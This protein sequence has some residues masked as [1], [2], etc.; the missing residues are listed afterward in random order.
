MALNVKDKSGRHIG[1]VCKTY[2]DHEDILMIAL[3]EKVFDGTFCDV[4]EIEDYLSICYAC[5][6]IF[7]KFHKEKFDS[8]IKSLLIGEY[9][10]L[11]YM[12]R[13]TFLRFLLLKNPKKLKELIHFDE[14]EDG[15]YGYLLLD[16][17]NIVIQGE[18]IILDE[19]LDYIDGENPLK[20]IPL[21][22]KVIHYP[23]IY[24]DKESTGEG[25]LLT[26]DPSDNFSNDNVGGTKIKLLSGNF[27][28]DLEVPLKIYVKKGYPLKL[29]IKD[30][31]LKCIFSDGI[32]YRF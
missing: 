4:D 31:I 23:T 11:S 27:K 12:D 1:F 20:A 16:I 7:N 19:A 17:N 28:F 2:L 26:K 9:S 8:Y 24:L 5:R 25:I 32:I 22:S 3:T 18:D 10:K 13:F 6:T 15:V 29:F 30:N 14:K 21:F